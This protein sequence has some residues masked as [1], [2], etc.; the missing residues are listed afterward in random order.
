[1][2]VLSQEQR[3]EICCHVINHYLFDKVWNETESEYRVNIKPLLMKKGSVVGSISLMDATMLLPTTTHSYYVWAMSIETFNIGLKLPCDTWVDCETIANDYNTLLQVYS[4][5]GSMFHKAF[6]FLRYNLSRQ[7]LF[8]AARKDMVRACIPT[9]NEVIEDIYLTV[10]YDSDRAN[11]VR[12]LSRQKTAALATNTFRRQID[13]IIKSSPKEDCIQIYKNGIEVTPLGASI[14]FTDKDFIDIVVDENINFSVDIDITMDNQNP[15][16]LSKKD[17]TWKQLIH[18]PKDKNP[19]NK[20]I[21]HNTCDFWVRRRLGSEPY[22]KYLHRVKLEDESRD[23]VNQVTH[24]DMAIPLYVLDAYRDYVQMEELSLHIVAR[25]HDKDNVLIRDASFID[26]LYVHDD[27]RIIEILCGNGPENI[28]WWRADNLEQ[29]K[30]VEMMFDVPNVITRNTVADYV[31]ALG[32]YSVVNLLCQRVIDIVLTDGFKQS[33]TFR[34]PL[35]YWGYSVIPIVYLNSRV[36]SEDQL[37]YIVDTENNECTVTLKDD[38]KT[39][40]GDKMVC[41]FYLDGDKTIYNFMPQED[42]TSFDVPLEEFT[43]WAGS[44][45]GTVESY[46]TSYNTQYQQLREITHYVTHTNDD[47]TIRITVAPEFVGKRIFVQNKYCSYRESFNLKKYTADG[48]TI[49]IPLTVAYSDDELSDA[50]PAFNLQNISVYINGEYLVR[51]IEYTINSIYEDEN[52]IMHELVIQSMDHFKEGQDDICDIIINIAE[53]EDISSFFVINN[54]LRDSTP[55][56]LYFPNISLAHVN[57]ILERDATYEGVYMA[58]P[59]GKYSQGDIF[60]IQTSVPALVKDFI[61]RYTT[62][63]DLERIKILNDYFYDFHQLIPDVLV[64]EDKHRIYST[65]LNTFIHDVVAGIVPVTFDP[66]STRMVD[67]IKPYTH[68]QDNDLCFQLLGTN[69]QLFIDFYPQYINYSVSTEM[70]RFIDHFI[71]MYMPE[72]LDP[73]VEVVYEQR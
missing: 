27:A 19:D 48:T 14:T 57:G 67:I 13:E 11:D 52:L 3:E 73:T 54:E 47:G 58:L 33:L 43:V 5:S 24:N 4:K 69:N 70:K 66:D 18:I 23:T 36:L 21:T 68:L 40:P 55:V 17:S 35:L 15:V 41:V 20:I 64:M 60:E 31:S 10:Y 16:F 29:S 49:A 53:M 37:E 9:M 39:V 7:I 6:T 28:P 1:M 62:N 63:E 65:F 34:L 12:V 56:N 30:F 44:P 61:L 8:L 38:I 42:N 2:P 72:N 46:N 51:G 71:T 50:C 59:E 45:I 32:F 25:I 26:L 22:G